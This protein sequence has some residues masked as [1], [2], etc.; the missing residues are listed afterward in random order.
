MTIQ[1]LLQSEFNRTARQTTQIVELLE[2]GNTIPFIAR[3]RKEATGNLDDQ[4]LRQL[5]VRYDQLKALEERRQDIL[6]LLQEQDVLDDLL[7]EQIKKATTLTELDDLYRP[8]RPKRKTRAGIS[9]E[10]G[11]TP[12]AELALVGGTSRK[13]LVELADAL[14]KQPQAES[15]NNVDQAIAGAMDILAE[16]IADDP[17]VRR[18]LRREILREGVVESSRTKQ[19]GESVYEAYYA[20]REPVN[21][22]AAHRILAINRGE[23]EKLLHVKITLPTET[24]LPLLTAHVIRQKNEVADLLHAMLA[25]AWKRLLQPSLENEIRQMLTEQAQEK[26]LR[27]FESNLRSLLMQPPV[28]GHRV[29]GL[30]P[31]YRTGCKLAA[32]DETGRLLETAVIYPTPPHNQEKAAAVTVLDLIHRHHISLIAIG[33]GTASRESELFIRELVRANSLEVRWLVVNEAGASV[34]SASELGASEFPEFDVSLRSAVSIARRL[35]D[36]LA[37][38]VKIEP[39]AIGVGQ[40]QHDLNQKRL[41]EALGGVVEACVNEVGVDLN[42][43]SPSLLAHVAGLSPVVARNLVAFREKNGAFRSRFQL[44]QIPRLG[45]KAFE[46]SAGF[47]RIPGADEPLDNTSVH[48]ESYDKVRKLSALIGLPPSPELAEKALNRNLPELASHLDIGEWTLSDIVDSLLRPGRDPRD[49]FPQ[50]LLRS[51]LMELSD[52]RPDMVLQGVVRNVAD[53][54]AFVDLGMHQDG[55]V[56]ISELAD[57]FIKD[58]LTVVRVGQV[59]QVRVLSIDAVK[60]RISLSMK[61]LR[62]PSV[63]GHTLNKGSAGNDGRSGE[64]QNRGHS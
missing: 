33:N 10:Q 51:D 23:K 34:Y 11:L 62:Q 19:A 49:D 35:Q 44:T 8:F 37:E 1:E 32:V 48:P 45:P 58:P 29:L 56:H 30:D 17:W 55:L 18:R 28:H 22:I 5:A 38:L 3:Y 25:D 42:T 46:Q 13:D 21:A 9:I 2:D 15:L 20:F 52:L 47:L 60:K 59:V 43:V 57:H 63:P 41:D 50:P 40:Y 54:G 12:L 27:V 26:S 39:K 61:G 64:W 14:L 7:C 24:V 36:P 53:F 6:R 16:Q 31:A 4:S